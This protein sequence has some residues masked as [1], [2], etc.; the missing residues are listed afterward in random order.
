MVLVPQNW[1]TS[2]ESVGRRDA[3]VLG[4]PAFR[5]WTKRREQ[6]VRWRKRWSSVRSLEPGRKSISR[7]EGGAA[8][9]S[10]EMRILVRMR[11]VR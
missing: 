2:L 6:P 11:L 1:V 7:K 10:A 3:K 5:C 4:L 8:S 9:D